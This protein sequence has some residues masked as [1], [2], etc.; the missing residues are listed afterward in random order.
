MSDA[1][2]YW[3]AKVRGEDATAFILPTMYSGTY[4][5]PQP[6]AYKVRL[7]K[8]GPKVPMRIWLTKDGAAT[9]VW[10][11]GCGLT[12]TIDGTPLPAKAIAERWIWAEAVSKADLDHY[13][14][15]KL[16]PGEIGH[17]SGD[18]TLAEKIKDAIENAPKGNPTDKKSADVAS[19][20]R[21]KL[22]ALAKEADDER[23]AKVRPHLEAQRAINAEYKP[24]IDSAKKAADALRDGLTIWMREQEAKAKAKAIADAARKAAEEAA[25]AHGM[26]DVPLPLPEPPKVQAGG[27]RGRKAG[28]R[29]VTR[30]EV[31]NYDAVLEYLKDKPEFREMVATYAAKLMRAGENVTGMAV[32][33]ERVAA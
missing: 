25:K 24:L 18:L 3:K 27:Q 4:E 16:W 23:D 11:E 22:N 5:D 10:S 20:Y 31:D 9:A 32:I 15:H 29:T 6:G 26:E 21:D 2:A 33:T 28:L 1:Y 12:G 8:G 7:A 17:N 30:H 13:N 19:N 14:A